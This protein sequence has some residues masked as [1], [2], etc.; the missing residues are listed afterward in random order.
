MTTEL[1]STVSDEHRER[2][3]EIF[4]RADAC[5]PD[6]LSPYLAPDATLTVGNEPPLRGI[7]EV[8]AGSERFFSMI[9]GLRHEILGLWTSDR[10]TTIKLRVTY[11]RLDGGV[12]TI[13]VVTLMETEDGS[14]LIKEYS[15]YFDPA[16]V[17]A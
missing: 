10:A 14:D 17:F 16:P 13:P 4:A 9:A 2:V 1:R 11:T 3:K 6:G 15:V 7:D 5:D 8:R 12:V